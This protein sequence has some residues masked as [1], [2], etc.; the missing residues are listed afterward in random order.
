MEKYSRILIIIFF[1]CLFNLGLN[2][3]MLS[4]I[5]NDFKNT[6]KLQSNTSPMPTSKTA[7]ESAKVNLEN[8]SELATF[9]SDLTVI[10]AE[11]RALRE[12][13]GTT[14]SFEELSL[15]IKSLEPNSNE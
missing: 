12:L 13:L 14:K 8:K 15:L 4:N 11:I 9:Q 5:K 3:Y 7:T 6:N 1:L 2:F 10:K